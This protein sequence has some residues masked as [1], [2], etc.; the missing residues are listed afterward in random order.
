MDTDVQMMG[1]S[2]HRSI[3]DARPVFMYRTIFLC[4]L[5]YYYNLNFWPDTAKRT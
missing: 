5:Y 3:L 2:Y 4:I 1:L